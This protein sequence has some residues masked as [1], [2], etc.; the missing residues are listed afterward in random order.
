M[1]SENS[2]RRLCDSGIG[3]L[4]C[5]CCVAGTNQAMLLIFLLLSA[6]FI[7]PIVARTER[8]GAARLIP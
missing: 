3:T 2:W 6:H 8:M 7:R 5:P 4:L 1:N